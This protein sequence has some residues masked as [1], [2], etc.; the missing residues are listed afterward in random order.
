MPACPIVVP[1]FS[2]ELLVR[3]PKKSSIARSIY[4]HGIYE[5]QLT[6]VIRRVVRPGMTI[7]D[8]GA[9]IGYYAIQ[10][11]D[12]VG[13][14]GRVVAFEPTRNGRKFLAAN[15]ILNDCSNIEIRPEALS[16]QVGE[17]HFGAS[18]VKSQMAFLNQPDSI[19][20]TELETVKMIPYDEWALGNPLKVVD[21]VKIDVEGVDVEGAELLVLRGMKV[22]LARARPILIIEVHPA[23]MATFGT[24]EEE[25]HRF[26]KGLGYGP[27][28]HIYGRTGIDATDTH[29]AMWTPIQMG[30]TESQ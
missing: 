25:L 19:Q 26:L 18:N 3:N 27:P 22:L 1:L 12:L 2:G 28:Q 7:V 23:M 21:L 6:A 13:S 8:V 30:Q 10:F 11:T 20:E 24:T 14:Q 4:L 29:Q 16:D 5:R 17:V 15:A 9:D